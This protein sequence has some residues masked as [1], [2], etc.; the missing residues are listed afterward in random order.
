VGVLGGTFDPVH[1]GHLALAET[2]RDATGCAVW[3]LPCA[4]PPHKD[5]RGV[6]PAAHRAA[7]LALAV[8]GR[9]G[10]EIC[11]LELR[12]GAVQYTLDTLRAARRERG[13]DP[14]FLLGLDALAEIPTW[15][16]PADLLAE[17]DLIAVDR[18]GDRAD[19]VC[20]APDLHPT[21]VDAPLQVDD[22]RRARLGSGG[23]VFRLSMT[24]VPVS[25]RE[26]RAAAAAGRRLHRLV[27]AAVARYIHTSGLYRRAEERE[28]R[29]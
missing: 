2:V 24:R 23:R 25:S 20:V 17:F 12:T 9:P 13:V 6:S 11:D 18:A 16:R 3:L 5:P 10:L 1:F 27:P 7:M 22:W 8:D 4:I 28:E 14:V 21:I 26:V 29:R 15:S 19:L